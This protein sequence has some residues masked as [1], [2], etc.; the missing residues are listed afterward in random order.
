[1]RLFRLIIWVTFLVIALYAARQTYLTLAGMQPRGVDFRSYFTA[2]W[3]VR[4]HQTEEIYLS[5][6]NLNPALQKDHISSGTPFAR[7]AAEHSVFT[8]EIELYDYPPT[9]ADLIVPLTW[10]ST[11]TALKLWFLLNIAALVWAAYLLSRLPALLLSTG[12]LPI[13]AFLFFPPTVSALIYGQVVIY[14]LLIVVAGIGLY[15]R[16]MTYSAA[17]LFALAIAIKLTPLILVVP[18]IL[19]RDWKMVRAVALWGVA[20]LAALVILNGW[21]SLS[22]YIHEIARMGGGFEVLNRSLTSELQVIWSHARRGPSLPGLATEGKVLDLLAFCYAAW[23]SRSKSVRD[24]TVRYKVETFAYFL[25]LS[26]CLSPV[27]WVHAYL[28]GAPALV[29]Y[30]KHLWDGHAKLYEALLFLL[31]IAALATNAILP[32]VVTTPLACLAL[33][34]LGLQKLRQQSVAGGVNATPIPAAG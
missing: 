18:L 29:L 8:D 32:L 12:F 23:Q 27:S 3:M 2:A 16:N 24:L 6:G 21:G 33:A 11:S 22:L 13:L 7:M 10:L 31:L 19:W 9:L 25:L 17:L 20:I 34:L 15:L 26:C 1:M 4:N 28:L 14:I 30:G 5:V